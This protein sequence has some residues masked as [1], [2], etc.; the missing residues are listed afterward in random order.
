MD[1][2]ARWIFPV[3][4][5]L[6]A[7]LSFILVTRVG[8]TSTDTFLQIQAAPQGTA[9]VIDG[10]KS[11]SGTHEINPGEHTIAFNRSGFGSQTQN[12]NA[13]GGKTVYVGAILQP[14]TSKTQDW[15][16]H[17]HSDQQLSQGIADHESDY[18]ATATV[19]ANPFL[20]L[21]PLSYGDGS[22]GR[23]TIAQ[24]VPLAG[25]NQ[26][27][28]YVNATTVVDRQGVLTYMR[29]RGY[30]PALMDIVFYDVANPLQI[31]GSE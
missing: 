17:H 10:H 4:L 6:V 5:L 19:Q 24:G 29:S 9:V 7:G 22:G 16:N 18:Q 15:Y 13:V 21:L 20:Q 25:S 28:I 1:M 27:A 12:I 30:D 23:V 11:S 14:N 3:F 2:N 8:Q 31:S 26:P